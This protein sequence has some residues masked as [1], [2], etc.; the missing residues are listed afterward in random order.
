MA[1]I[2]FFSIPEHRKFNYKPRYYDPAKEHI[3]EVEAKYDAEKKEKER[4]IPGMSIRK[5]YR[6]GSIQG[7]TESEGNKPM[8]RI[9]VFAGVILA[10]LV[11]FFLAKGLTIMLR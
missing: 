8:R 7:Q 4:Y 6:D 2:S 5:A 10:F 11:A 3:K 1:R 9:L